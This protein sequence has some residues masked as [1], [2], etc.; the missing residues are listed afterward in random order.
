MEFCL[1]DVGINIYNYGCGFVAI[2][3]VIRRKAP[4]VNFAQIILELEMNNQAHNLGLK[5]SN[6]ERYFSNHWIKY[7][8]YDNYSKFGSHVN[9]YSI[10]VVIIR[11]A[12]ETYTHV[13]CI[14]KIKSRVFR[15]LNYHDFDR[16]YMLV[17]WMDISR[18]F[19]CAFGIK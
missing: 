6:I 18:R 13:F 17:D 14:T 8:T 15:T 7:D 5:R 12:S 3:N 1:S 11:Q 19:V 9:D 16:D 2:Y 10:S 4:Y